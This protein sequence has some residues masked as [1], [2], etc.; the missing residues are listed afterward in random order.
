MI[1][2]SV[3]TSRAAN[4]LAS[5][6]SLMPPKLA[7][8]QGNGPLTD[9]SRMLVSSLRSLTKR[10]LRP[11]P[12]NCNPADT[13]CCTTYAQNLGGRRSQEYKRRRGRSSGFRMLRHC[14]GAMRSDG[15]ALNRSLRKPTSSNRSRSRRMKYIFFI[16]QTRVVCLQSR[17]HPHTL[18]S[19]QSQAS[20]SGGTLGCAL[21]DEFVSWRSGAGGRRQGS[22]RSAG[23]VM[24][25]R[26][27]CLQRSS[28]GLASHLDANIWASYT[29]IL[30][31]PGER[32]TLRRESRKAAVRTT[33]RPCRSRICAGRAMPLN[34]GQ[35][36]GDIHA[37]PFRQKTVRP[38]R[39]GCSDRELYD[40]V[41]GAE[42]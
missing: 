19:S 18:T 37:F 14:M 27:G 42:R 2:I 5:G 7:L 6:R 32:Y 23:A 31:V 3:R 12:R 9:R 4:I 35:P 30:T 34:A 41:D 24:V 11:P 33:R 15:R 16:W 28:D 26:R 36:T 20:C 25:R 40:A 29:L 8:A 22:N 1:T 17:C 21:L 10:A 38:A 39:N 13:S